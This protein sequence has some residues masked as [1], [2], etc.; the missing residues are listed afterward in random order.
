[1]KL[2]FDLLGGL[3]T[4]G[5]IGSGL[6]LFICWGNYLLQATSQKTLKPNMGRFGKKAILRVILILVGFLIFDAI[7]IACSVMLHIRA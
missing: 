2:L 1:M 7:Y 5:S 3:A 6:F 4:I